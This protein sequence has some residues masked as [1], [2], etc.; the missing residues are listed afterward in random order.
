MILVVVNAV[1]R[2]VDVLDALG[3]RLPLT[4]ELGV[5]AGDLVDGVDVQQF[6][7]ARL[8][9]GQVVLLQAVEHPFILWQRRQVCVHL[10]GLGL[11]LIFE[12]VHGACNTVI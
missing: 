7:E 4:V 8:E 12:A 3:D 9:S 10:H 6:F 1:Q 2:L 11:E 5:K